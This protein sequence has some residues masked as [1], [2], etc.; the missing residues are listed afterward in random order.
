MKFKLG[1]MFLLTLLLVLLSSC[2]SQNS[3]EENKKPIDHKLSFAV[4][5]SLRN[6]VR[7]SPLYVSINKKKLDLTQ[8][9]INGI[10]S[11]ADALLVTLLP[12]HELS[13][14]PLKDYFTLSYQYADKTIEIFIQNNKSNNPQNHIY[15][16]SIDNSRPGYYL[17]KGGEKETIELIDLI[18]K[19]RDTGQN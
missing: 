15:M 7:E 11:K 10:K 12:T 18:I 14:L 19:I 3:N 9:E 6:S 8:T 5:D 13:K 2:S 4:E 16:K 17:L 1:S